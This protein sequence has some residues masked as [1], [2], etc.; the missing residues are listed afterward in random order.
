MAGFMQRT[1]RDLCDNAFEG[2][3]NAMTEHYAYLLAEQIEQDNS[4]HYFLSLSMQGK[5]PVGFVEFPFQ[6]CTQLI[7]QMLRDPESQIGEEDRLSALE[8]SILQDII[9]AITDSLRE[10]FSTYGEIIL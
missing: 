7:A 3:F 9:I 10:G 4:N 1:L 6:T 8:K 5:G 2:N